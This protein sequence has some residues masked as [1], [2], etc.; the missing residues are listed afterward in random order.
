MLPIKP[1][2]WRRRRFEWYSYQTHQ[3]RRRQIARLMLLLLA[4][5]LTHVIAMMVF[6][7]LGLAD[8]IWLTLTTMTT[9]G[10]G[11]Y[12]AQTGF[13]RLLTIILMYTVGIFLLAQIAGEWIDYRIARKER[14]RT[15]QWRWH[16]KDH[17]L[18]INTP[19]ADGR[20]YLRVLVEQIR[21]TPALQDYPIEV[22]SSGFPGGLPQEI[23]DMG[24][25][26][27]QGVPEGRTSLAEVD[28]DKAKFIILMAVDTIEYRSDSLS[29]DIL[30]QLASFDVSGYVV[31]ECVLDANRERLRRKGA[32]A[33]IRPVRAYPELMVRAMAAPGTEKIFED[34]FE[35]E[36]N[37]T[38][39]YDVSFENQPWGEMAARMLIGGVGTPVGFLDES[40]EVKINPAPGVMATGQAVFV[41]VDQASKPD[42]AR[43]EAALAS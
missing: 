17:I 31:A 43:V 16:M 36:G 32:H 2:F 30:D 24:V 28:V 4:V 1:Y 18:I 29:L 9:V 19:E 14:M 37:H 26:L 41:I 10:Y 27:H 11:D 20:R 15:G 3:D 25:V 12:S 8:A 7:D 40:G 21:R 22:L 23:A 33:V 35:H 34:L 13:G 6:E 42:L 5:A 39:R 38:R